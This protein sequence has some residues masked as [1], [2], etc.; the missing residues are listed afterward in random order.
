V[1]ALKGVSFIAQGVA[2]LLVDF[3]WCCV[4]LLAGRVALFQSCVFLFEAAWDD[5]EGLLLVDCYWRVFPCVVRGIAI[6]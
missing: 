1:F 6:E 3:P 4:F 2:S 5:K